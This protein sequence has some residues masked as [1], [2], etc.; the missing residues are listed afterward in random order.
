MKAKTYDGI[1]TLVE[2]KA[3]FGK[4][5]IPKGTLGTIVECYEQPQEGYAVDLAI[6][7]EKRIGGFDYENVII[8]PEQFVV[9]NPALERQDVVSQY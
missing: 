3:N 7:N 1:R 5:L 9:V 6:P 4:R 2:I 8:F